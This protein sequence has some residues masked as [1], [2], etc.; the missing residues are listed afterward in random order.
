L[1]LLEEHREQRSQVTAAR[2]SAHLEHLEALLFIVRRRPT[3]RRRRRR[4][5]ARVLVLVLVGELFWREEV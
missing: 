1:H 2:C 3:H 5:R 4:R